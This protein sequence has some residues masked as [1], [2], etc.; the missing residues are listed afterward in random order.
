[1]PQAEGGHAGKNH[2]FCRPR[3]LAE[4]LDFREKCRRRRMGTPA[5]TT[6]FAGRVISLRAST[7]AKNAAG[8]FRLCKEVPQYVDVHPVQRVDLLDA[9]A[10]V[11]LVDRR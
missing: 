2:A 4:G 1:M 5:K 3:N 7:S 8:I 9:H 11:H 10:L 6:L